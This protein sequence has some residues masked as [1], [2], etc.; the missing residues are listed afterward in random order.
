LFITYIEFFHKMHNKYL[1][2]FTTKIQLMLSQVN[3]DIKFDGNKHNNTSKQ[4][5]KQVLKTIKK[6]IPYGD[7]ELIKEIRHTITDEESSDTITDNNDPSSFSPNTVIFKYPI[8]SMPSPSPLIEEE[9]EHK[10]FPLEEGVQETH[11]Q[12]EN[13]IISVSEISFFATENETEPPALPPPPLQQQQPT[14][15]DEELIVEFGSF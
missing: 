4:I 14:T 3:Y 6:D 11:A 10:D 5:N 8:P 1:S 15:Q 2:R 13:Q 9:H 7:R 12:Q